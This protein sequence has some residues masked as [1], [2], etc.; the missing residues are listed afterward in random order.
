[1]KMIMSGF[2]SNSQKTDFEDVNI[3]SYTLIACINVF[4][5]CS[6]LFSNTINN[7]ENSKKLFN[8]SKKLIYLYFC[9]Y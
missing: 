7:I 5:V 8:E 1:M 4:I 9:K 2:L 6:I 3:I